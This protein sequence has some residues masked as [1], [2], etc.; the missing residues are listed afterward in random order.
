[1]SDIDSR[2]K[3]SFRYIF[4]R[5][6]ILL[7]LCVSS[8]GVLTFF[9]LGGHAK[10]LL[11]SVVYKDSFIYEQVNCENVSTIDQNNS[12]DTPI[13]SK[14]FDQV[15]GDEGE[16]VADI[17]EEVA[18][19]VI[20]IGVSGDNFS[21]DRIIGTGFLVSNNGILVTNRHVVEMT[22]LEYF[23]SFK[24][25]DVS[26]PVTSDSIFLDP[27][28]DIA[29]IK[30]DPD[31]IPSSA[32]I[33]NI[34]DSDSLKLGQTVIAIGN[35]LGTYTGSITKGI[36]SGLNREVNISKD[37]FSTQSEVYEDVI[38][39]DAA[40]NSGNSGGPLLNLNA[41]VIGVNF[42]TVEGASNLSFALP[43]NRIKDRILE[44]EQYG[45]FK[46]PY[47]G[48]EYRTRLVFLNGHSIVGAEVV[49]IVENSPAFSAGLQTGDIIIEFDG[50]DLSERTLSA[51]IQDRAIGDSVSIIIIRNRLEQEIKATIGER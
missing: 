17:V 3:K 33:L 42:A 8:I 2:S 43:I 28:N 44:F 14:I 7:F 24:D 6:G 22:G 45:K 39:T 26:V 38:Q 34:G 23:I 30:I 12:E 51:L 40:I 32:K 11:C 46:I 25:I 19:G 31:Q 18:G 48:V 16:R 10:N 29:L 49:N 41:E 9:I 37:F 20:G 50:T 21:E 47:I 35:P 13:Q 4:L 5:L 1:M 15:S 36:I 27:V